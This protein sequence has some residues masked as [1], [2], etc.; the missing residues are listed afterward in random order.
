MRTQI[1]EQRF[2]AVFAVP[3]PAPVTSRERE[4]DFAN[5]GRARLGDEPVLADLHGIQ[6]DG[7]GGLQKQTG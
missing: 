4:T 6:W 7:G 3:R 1:A 5:R 2:S